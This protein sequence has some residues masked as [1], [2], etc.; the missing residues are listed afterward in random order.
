M[1]KAKASKPEKQAEEMSDRERIDAWRRKRAQ[2]GELQ[3]P[4]AG[5]K[6]SS[7]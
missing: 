5:K 7:K 4:K 1:P 3:K 2:Q 6:E